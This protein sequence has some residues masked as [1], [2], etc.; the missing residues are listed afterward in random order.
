MLE[1]ILGN[2]LSHSVYLTLIQMN[3]KY[4]LNKLPKF[5]RMIQKS[6]AMSNTTDY[7]SI[8]IKLLCKLSSEMSNT[9]YYCTC[10]V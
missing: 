4:M 2:N 6:Y 8:Y 7:F 3:G 5:E 1:V 10:I 9:R